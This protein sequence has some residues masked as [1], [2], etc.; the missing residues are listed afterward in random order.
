M[1]DASYNRRGTDTTGSA[2]ATGRPA[3]LLS[4]RERKR[5]LEPVQL[6]SRNPIY[7]GGGGAQALARIGDALPA[8]CVDRAWRRHH[9][10]RNRRMAACSGPAIHGLPLVQHRADDAV[11]LD[12][13]MVGH[14]RNGLCASHGLSG[15]CLLRRPGSEDEAQ[16]N[17]S[18]RFNDTLLISVEI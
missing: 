7:L 11:C 6:L 12:A 8:E 1:V 9:L 14:Q 10:L 16:K 3:A 18:V 17:G 4:K 5:P 2:R 15:E 13:R